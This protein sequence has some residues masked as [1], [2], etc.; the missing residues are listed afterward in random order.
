MQQDS[1]HLTD[2]IQ[3]GSAPV[4]GQTLPSLLGAV[5]M[6]VAGYVLARVLERLSER[7]FRRGRPNAGAPARLVFWLVMIAVILVAAN[8]LGFD[9]GGSNSHPP[10]P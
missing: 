1:A 6:L 3:T 5:I 9:L 10:S 4:F 2:R 7:W 8:S